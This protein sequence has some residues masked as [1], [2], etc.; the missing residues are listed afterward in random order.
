MNLSQVIVIT[1]I[2]VYFLMKKQLKEKYTKDYVRSIRATL[3]VPILQIIFFTMF[4]KGGADA[5]KEAG[6]IDNLH[7]ISTYT[8]YLGI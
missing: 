8:P 6:K 7:N 4:Y 1:G 3:I 2:T 5:T